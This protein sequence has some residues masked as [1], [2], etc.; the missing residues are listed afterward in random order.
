MMPSNPEAAR[1]RFRDVVRRAIERA[2]R[3]DEEHFARLKAVRPRDV[4]AR[5]AGWRDRKLS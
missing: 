3:E 1:E 5:T 4:G 2:R